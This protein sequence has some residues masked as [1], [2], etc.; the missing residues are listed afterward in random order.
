MPFF[1]VRHVETERLIG[2]QPDGAIS[3]NGGRLTDLANPTQPSDA[4][5]LA[6]LGSKLPVAGTGLLTNSSNNTLNV[7]TRQPHIVELGTLDS[8]RTNGPI[9]ISST[10]AGSPA[11]STGA[12]RVAGGIRAGGTSYIYGCRPHCG[13]WYRQRAARHCD[14][15]VFWLIWHRGAFSDRHV[16]G[17]FKCH[18]RMV[19]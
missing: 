19:N 6:F 1:K 9:T 11:T 13:W 12:L 14:F 18:R 16:V 5:H 10:E 4:V 17:T 3:L 2:A 8:L 7:H 15:N